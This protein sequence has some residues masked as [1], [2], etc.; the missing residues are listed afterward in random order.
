M[1]KQ[2]HKKIAH[3]FQQ[4]LRLASQSR[5]FWNKTAW[6]TNWALF[7]LPTI[8]PKKAAPLN[9]TLTQNWYWDL[10]GVQ[11]HRCSPCHAHKKLPRWGQWIGK[12]S[13]GNDR[14]GSFRMRNGYV[15]LLSPNGKKVL[16]VSCFLMR[17]Y[18]STFLENKCRCLWPDLMIPVEQLETQKDEGVG[19]FQNVHYQKLTSHPSDLGYA[20]CHQRMISET[21]DVP[22]LLYQLLHASGA[23]DWEFCFFARASCHWMEYLLVGQPQL[24]LDWALPLELQQ[25]F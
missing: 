22:P 17:L 14:A 8:V 13:P 12:G 19:V 3:T 9:S 11:M 7:L 16:S 24:P 4:L 6:Q 21:F 23:Q 10:C 20:S 15:I 5:H 1:F 18:R 25:N 2:V